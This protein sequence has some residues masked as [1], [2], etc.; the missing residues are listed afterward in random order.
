MAT[1][2][3]NGKHAIRCASSPFGLPGQ[4]QP[5]DAG[6]IEDPHG[7]LHAAYGSA[8]GALYLVR[9]DGHVCWRWAQAQPATA[10]QIEQALMRACAHLSGDE[11]TIDE[12]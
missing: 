1:R 10:Q 5:G 7:R 3:G 11:E 6:M 9:P 4:P 12:R 2:Y 8:Q